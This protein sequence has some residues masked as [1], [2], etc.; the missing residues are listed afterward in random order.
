MNKITF[1]TMVGFEMIWTHYGRVNAMEW[2]SEKSGIEFTIWD[3][4]LV[5]RVELIKQRVDYNEIMEQEKE[6]ME[7]QFE[8]LGISDLWCE[9]EMYCA[10]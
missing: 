2:L 9:V 6:A 7:N 5:K 1:E 8:A 10:N 4:F 3:E